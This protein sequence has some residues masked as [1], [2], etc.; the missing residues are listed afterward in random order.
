LPTLPTRAACL[1]LVR[2]MDLPK[3]RRYRREADVAAACAQR[4]RAARRQ[5]DLFKVWQLGAWAAAAF[6]AGLF[7]RSGVEPW[8]FATSASVANTVG[9]VVATS[10]AFRP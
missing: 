5:P 6:N 1:V 4:A 7:C 3:P 10:S 8:M 2:L 9:S